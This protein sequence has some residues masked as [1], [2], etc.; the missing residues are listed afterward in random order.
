MFILK[1]MDID[2][3]NEQSE[4]KEDIIEIFQQE[5]NN[6]FD[7]D[8]NEDNNIILSQYNKKGKKYRKIQSKIK[9]IKYAKENSRIDAIKKYNV[10]L[11]QVQK[12]I[13]P[14]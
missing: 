12:Y 1:S 14:H 5:E 13:F 3:S 9:I 2:T 6:D 4:N 8:F 10:Y 11:F 7:E